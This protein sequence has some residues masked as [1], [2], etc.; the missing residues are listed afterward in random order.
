MICRDIN[1]SAAPS[2]PARRASCGT[3]SSPAAL[4]PGTRL[5]LDEITEEF[6]TSRTPI[7]EALL[8]LSYEG[9]VEVAPRS[10]ITVLGISPEATIDNF[11]VLATLSGK[12]AEWA[13]D[14][15]GPDDLGQLEEV[16]GALAAARPGPTMVDLNWRFHRIINQ[17][18]GSQQLLSLIR[19]AVRMIPSNFLEVMPVHDS[20]EHDHLLQALRSG[21][22]P[23][24]RE[25]AERHVLTAGKSLAKWLPGRG[26]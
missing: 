2:G 1:R 14:R 16:A 20:S 21:Q 4:P 6:G 22:A 25:I 17:A 19:Q 3:G 8:E 18:A 26:Q 7:R 13:A 11:A 12:A 5:D 10:G 9:L 23:Q 24:A 15:I